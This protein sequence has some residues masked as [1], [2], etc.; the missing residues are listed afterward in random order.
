MTILA[1]T[2]KEKCFTAPEEGCVKSYQRYSFLEQHLISG[3]HKYALENQTLYD[4]AMILYATK[5][6][7]GAGPAPEVVDDMRIRSVDGSTLPMGWALKSTTVT[8]KKLHCHSE[9][10]PNGDV[11]SWGTDEAKG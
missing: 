2:M 5:L 8:R 10:L 4:K 11:S 9:E 7:Q 1:A 6:E 3:R